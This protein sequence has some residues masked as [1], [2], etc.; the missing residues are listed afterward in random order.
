MTKINQNQNKDSFIKRLEA[1]NEEAGKTIY[2]LGEA[3]GTITISHNDLL[4]GP[5]TG[6]V[7]DAIKVLQFI[8]DL[9]GDTVYYTFTSKIH[10]K[11]DSIVK[12]LSSDNKEMRELGFEI[13]IE[14]ISKEP[15]FDNDSRNYREGLDYMITNI[16]TSLNHHKISS[17]SLIYNNMGLNVKNFKLV[18]KV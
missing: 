6:Y 15:I 7:V 17:Y 10:D 8:I 5:R 18:T 13:L 1:L 9:Y 3:F 11:V 2:S 16:T 14:L 4:D 12:Y